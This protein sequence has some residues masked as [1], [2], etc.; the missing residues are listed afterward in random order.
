MIEAALN[1]FELAML[2]QS[3]IASESR[4]T[5]SSSYSIWLYSLMARTNSRTLTSPKHELWKE[6]QVNSGNQKW[7]GGGKTNIHF[8]R[9]LRCPP[10][11]TMR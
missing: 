4:E 3:V 9:S 7:R 1:H 5:L 2:C 10:T 11:S 8:F 6:S